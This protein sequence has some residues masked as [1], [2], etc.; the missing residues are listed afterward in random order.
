MQGARVNAAVGE[1]KNVETRSGCNFEADV[2][3]REGD[4]CTAS[5]EQL[6]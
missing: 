3:V 1:N 2:R 5:K 4:H 6:K